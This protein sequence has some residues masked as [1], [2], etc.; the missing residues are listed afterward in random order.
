MPL[1]STLPSHSCRRE[2][3]SQSGKKFQSVPSPSSPIFSALCCTL[4]RPAPN[5]RLGC[6]YRDCVATV[7][8]SRGYRMLPVDI[9]FL[10]SLPLFF[11]LLLALSFPRY[12]PFHSRAG[13]ERNRLSED[14]FDREGFEEKREREREDDAH[15]VV[16][17]KAY[18]LEN[19]RGEG[20]GRRWADVHPKNRGYHG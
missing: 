20:K 8:A 3:T 9:F 7:A 15:R 4:N 16:T 10:L 5:S 14:T 1:L 19:K 17:R 11:F 13:R 6:T 2:T 18:T 12:P